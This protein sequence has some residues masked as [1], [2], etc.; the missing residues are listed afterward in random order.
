MRKQQGRTVL[1]S[2]PVPP[3]HPGHAV[4][5]TRV[6]WKVLGWLCSFSAITYIGRICIIQ[7][8]PDIEQSLSLTPSSMAYAFSAFSLAYALFE[9]PS[10][11]LGDRLGPRKVITRIVLCW[12]AFTGLT[13]AAWN[14]ASLVV[15][16]F[17]F[18]VGEAGAFPNIARAGREWFPFSERGLAQG[19]VWMSARW[20]GAVAPLM[21]MV[22]AY[23]WGWRL[24]FVLLS[25]LGLVWLWGFYSRFKDSPREDPSVNDAE[26]AL[27]A[28]PAKDTSTVAPLS[29]T[30]MLRSPTLW[31]L[32]LMY[33]GSNAGWSF[34][35]S[36]ITPYLQKDLH[37]SGVR[38]AGALVG[39]EVGAHSP[40][41]GCL[42][43]RGLAPAGDRL[44]HAQSRRARLY[45]AV[46]VFFYQGFWNGRKLG[47]H[48]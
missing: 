44:E 16:R 22:L 14:L 43:R 25:V 15:F 31:A 5:P 19:F 33:F 11:W 38:L 40:G 26:R 24:G 13:G 41:S 32:S 46:S 23:R 34:F 45:C 10:G 9:I 6:R 37:L 42:W 30:T 28:G 47:N 18:G 2:A 1:N 29:W 4:Q 17:L 39:Q 7:V 20:G 35:A 21:I 8:R 27:I 48:H 36:W 12:V 3:E